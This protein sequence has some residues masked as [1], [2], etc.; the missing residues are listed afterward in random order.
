MSFH[1]DKKY[2]LKQGIILEHFAGNEHSEQN[3]I[4]TRYNRVLHKT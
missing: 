1:Y 4:A 3:T 2:L